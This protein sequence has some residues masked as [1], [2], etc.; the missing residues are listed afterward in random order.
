MNVQIPQNR[1]LIYIV[2]SL[3]IKLEL[4]GYG[5]KTPTNENL[6]Q[7]IVLGKTSASCSSQLAQTS[8]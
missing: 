5:R 6:F 8:C 3:D 1:K 2:Y 4:I 7:K